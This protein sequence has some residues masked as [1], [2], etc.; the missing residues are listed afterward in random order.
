MNIQ[1]TFVLTACLLLGLSTL[2]SCQK[3][4]D[5]IIEKEIITITD[6]IIVVDTVTVIETII[7]TIPDTATTY[8]L[9][10]HAETS[11]GGSDPSLS[12]VGTERAMELSRILENVPLNAVLSTNFNRTRQ[13]AQ[14]VASAKGLT[15]Q[16]YDP[17]DPNG[18]I[19]DTQDE[20]HNGFVLIVGH[21]N[22]T[23]D[24]LNTMIDEDLYNTLPESAYNNL[25]IVS[26]FEK[27]RAKV[28]HLLY[29]N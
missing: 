8:I 21:S 14:P 3:D 20:F 12:I 27:G 25:Y 11:G 18:V 1:H 19:D 29:G 26:L 16:V 7:E 6:T 4:P 13:T 17:F 5:V 10:R 15:I 24:F 28:V 22:T 23:P 2:P 9:V